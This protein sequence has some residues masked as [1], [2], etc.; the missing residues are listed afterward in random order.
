MLGLLVN[1]LDADD[2]YPVL[3]REKLTM[4]IQKQLSQKQKDFPGFF[5]AF[6]KYRLNI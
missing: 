1:R 6:F 3:N 4:S 5:A 2:E